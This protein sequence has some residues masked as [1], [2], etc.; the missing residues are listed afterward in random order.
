MRHEEH[1]DAADGAARRKGRSHAERRQG[2]R[3][4]ERRVGWLWQ[5][6]V[7]WAGAPAKSTSLGPT[8]F[9]RVEQV[10]QERLAKLPAGLYA[11]KLRYGGGEGG[12]NPSAAEVV[13]VSERLVAETLEALAAAR[14]YPRELPRRVGDLEKWC[15]KAEARL[16]GAASA[17]RGETA[18]EKGVRR[19]GEY[20]P[21]LP[22][23]A[24]RG[25]MR[26]LLDS[27]ATTMAVSE[28][29]WA[30]G[31]GRLGE[32][33]GALPMLVRHPAWDERLAGLAGRICAFGDPS[34]MAA[35]LIAWLETCRTMPLPPEAESPARWR[36]LGGLEALESWL[37]GSGWIAANVARLMEMA[38]THGEQL[39]SFVLGCGTEGRT[40]FWN[41]AA[42]RL[43]AAGCLGGLEAEGCRRLVEHGLW[44]AANQVLKRH[45]ERLPQLAGLDE[46]WLATR[47]YDCWR[48]LFAMDDGRLLS[49]LLEFFDAAAA[50]GV[51]REE[52]LLFAEHLEDRYVG[53][54]EHEEFLGRHF[55]AVEALW[56]GLRSARRVEEGAGLTTFEGCVSGFP[57]AMFLAVLIAAE[58][59]GWSEVPRLAEIL[60]RHPPELDEDKECHS[61]CLELADGDLARFEKLLAAK[62]PRPLWDHAAEALAGWRFLERSGAARQ[63][64]SSCAEQEEARPRVLRLLERVALALQIQLREGLE[65]LLRVWERPAPGPE[66]AL[67]AALPGDVRSSLSELAA[68]PGALPESIRKLLERPEAMR[69]ELAALEKKRAEGTLPP[70]AA[71]RLQNLEKYLSDPQRLSEWVGEEVRAACRQELPRARLRALE[72]ALDEAIRR[73]WQAVLGP[74]QIPPGDSGWDNALRLHYHAKSNRRVLKALL[75]QM[76]E[77]RRG[78][79]LDHPGNVAF[80]QEMRRRGIDVAAWEGPLR[81]KFSVHGRE[82]EAYAEADP[83]RI[84]EMGNLFDTCLSVGRYND[85]STIANAVEANKRVLYLKDERGAIVGRKLIGLV[86]G[87]E[88][89][90][91][92]AVLIGFRSYGARE[93]LLEVREDDRHGRAWVKIVFDLFCHDI[94]VKVRARL[95]SEEDA[96]EELSRP[97]RL[98]TRWYN[99]GA[100]NFDPWVLKAGAGG[101]VL[102]AGGAERVVAVLL[103][104]V[105]ERVLSWADYPGQR[106]AVVRA[107][108]WLGDE[109]LR[110]LE[111]LHLCVLGPEALAFL[112]RHSPSVDVQRW[113]VGHM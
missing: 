78:W 69:R 77:G 76:L 86:P 101:S 19:V 41:T 108:L 27:P 8:Q 107:L 53:R 70:Q 63:L 98:F 47:R 57:F 73:R 5:P 38:G 105:E 20:R 37:A 48:G 14:R 103:R 30:G 74:G 40:E 44:D 100:E 22:G 106:P 46:G 96:Q 92:G 109:A 104:T 11:V 3:G 91:G 65:D 110:V 113:I 50:R 62:K 97:L 33:L 18:P 64:L 84:F 31:E 39:L 7:W 56:Q 36:L 29:L 12:I 75:R 45:P 89:T 6:L 85:Y 59:Q 32:F 15:G 35:H 94:A 2:A 21:E 28:Y 71:G 23:L 13:G 111:R 10:L 49:R 34:L 60:L 83:L 102:E 72:Q 67:P 95:A 80:E 68:Y 25:R 51:P 1:E 55:W 43:R 17:L 26:H 99:D 24:S 90:G 81:R 79:P 61:L 88:E 42:L 112:R 52:I 4:I 9:R 87:P 93:P 16:R 66:P 58:E 82:W 54:R